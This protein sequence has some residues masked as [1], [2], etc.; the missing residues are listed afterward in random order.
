MLIEDKDFRLSNDGE[1]DYWDLEL[2]K[3]VRPKG[4][5]ERQEFQLVGYGYSFPNALKVIANYRINAKQ[6][7][8]TLKQYI[9][10]YKN[11]V[12]T[13]INLR[14]TKSRNEEDEEETR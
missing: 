9:Q 8:Y 13:L 3:T 10:D 4:K 7:V 1:S 6:D 11:I 5:P 2:L 14:Q 12:D